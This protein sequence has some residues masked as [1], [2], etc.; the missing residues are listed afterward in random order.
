MCLQ[1]LNEL[2]LK[3]KNNM[4]LTSNDLIDLILIDMKYKDYVLDFIST[5]D[6]IEQTKIIRNLIDKISK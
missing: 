2:Y 3:L 6:R 1:S 4:P 5:N